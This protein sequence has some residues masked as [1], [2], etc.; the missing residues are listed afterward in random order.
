MGLIATGW[1]MHAGVEYRPGDE[2]PPGVDEDR[3][4]R[5]GLAEASAPAK[6]AAR[7]KARKAASD[8]PAPVTED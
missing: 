6:P 3:L 7:P 5:L 1:V 4:L 8:P 2:L